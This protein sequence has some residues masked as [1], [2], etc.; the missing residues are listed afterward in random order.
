MKK[1]LILTLLLTSVN[2]I[3]VV[4]I[5]AGETAPVSG[6]I[7]TPTEEKAVRKIKEEKLKLE[8]LNILKDRKIVLQDGRIKVLQKRVENLRFGVWYKVGFF[9]LGITFSALGVWGASKLLK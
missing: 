9:S 5:K 3:A 8:D 7:F 6:Y 2:T 4:P 1:L